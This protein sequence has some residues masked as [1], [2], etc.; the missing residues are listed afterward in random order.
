MIILSNMS[1]ETAVLREHSTSCTRLGASAFISN[2]Y[3]ELY[4]IMY[5]PYSGFS[6]GPRLQ[7][8]TFVGVDFVISPGFL[9]IL[10]TLADIF[11]FCCFDNSLACVF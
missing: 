2:N 11:D 8:V 6:L 4:N 3:Q 7:L 5:I 1:W 9:I 10:H